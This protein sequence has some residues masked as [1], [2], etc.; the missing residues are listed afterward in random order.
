MTRSIPS[1][2]AFG[3][4]NE[5]FPS[6][7]DPDE[8]WFEFIFEIQI[9]HYNHMVIFSQVGLNFKLFGKVLYPKGFGSTH[10][11]LEVLL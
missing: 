11:D 3:K 6:T 9:I 1:V 8:I 10:F 5:S 7:L 2:S 4:A